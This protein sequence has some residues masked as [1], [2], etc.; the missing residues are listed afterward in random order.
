[1][2]R[3]NIVWVLRFAAAPFFSGLVLLV[4]S[5]YMLWFAKPEIE[6]SPISAVAAPAFF[7][8]GDLPWFF[9]LAAGAGLVAIAW[10]AGA[11]ARRGD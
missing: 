5:I 1:M 11:R 4:T 6:A 9:A 8:F 2:L 10:N 3:F 7:A